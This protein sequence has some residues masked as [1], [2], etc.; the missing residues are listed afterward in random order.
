MN[1][2]LNDNLL[3]PIG[4]IGGT[5]GYAGSTSS[6]S[7][8]TAAGKYLNDASLLNALTDR[9]YQLLQADLELQRERVNN[10]SRPRWL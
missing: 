3:A 9:V 2:Q 7:K 6:G 5:A 1:S 10:Y 4:D 8:P